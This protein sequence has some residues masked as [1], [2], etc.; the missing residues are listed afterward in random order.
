MRPNLPSAS[1]TRTF[2]SLTENSRRV[3]GGAFDLR[4][5][6]NDVI[7]FLDEETLDERLPSWREMRSPVK[8]EFLGRAIRNALNQ[9]H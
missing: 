1:E 8:L 2:D 4:A 3:L 5:P 9:K 6:H 7:I